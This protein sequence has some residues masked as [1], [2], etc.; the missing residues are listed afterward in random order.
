MNKL[1]KNQSTVNYFIELF[2]SYENY[3]TNHKKTTMYF[4][5]K[6]NDRILVNLSGFRDADLTLC[7]FAVKTEIVNDKNVVTFTFNK[8]S[9]GEDPENLGINDKVVLNKH[10]ELHKLFYAALENRKFEFTSNDL[11]IVEDLYKDRNG[12][13]NVV[14]VIHAINTSD[15]LK[16]DLKMYMD[17]INKCMVYTD[18]NYDKLMSVFNDTNI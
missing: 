9:K 15:K 12:N 14:A 2:T 7:E 13:L 6:K 4:E 18:K 1:N 17:D 11:K 10:K 16:S 3:F 5:P 8:N